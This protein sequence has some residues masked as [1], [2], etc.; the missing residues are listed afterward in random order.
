MSISF[1]VI[2]QDM[3]QTAV[4]NSKS[5]NIETTKTLNLLAD[6]PRVTSEDRWMDRQTGRLGTLKSGESSHPPPAAQ[7]SICHVFFIR[8]SSSSSPAHD[9]ISPSI[10]CYLAANALPAWPDHSLLSPLLHR[11]LRTEEVQARVWASTDSAERRHKEKGLV[12]F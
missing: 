9:Q 6:N 2:R 7:L 4:R 1:M 5:Q 8:P 10:S 11:L 3:W 12:S